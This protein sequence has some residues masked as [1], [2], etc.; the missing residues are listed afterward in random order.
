M[1]KKNQIIK[2]PHLLNCK[3]NFLNEILQLVVSY[4]EIFFKSCSQGVGPLKLA[5]K[6]FIFAH[7]L[8]LEK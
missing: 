1:K 7:A 6:S 3:T 2:K 5:D 8:F 4:W